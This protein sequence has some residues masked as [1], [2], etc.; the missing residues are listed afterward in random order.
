LQTLH[1]PELTALHLESTSGHPVCLTEHAS[2]P[3]VLFFYPKDNT[4]GCSMEVQDFRDLHASFSTLNAHILG[5]SRDTLKSHQKFKEKYS[6]PFGLLADPEEKLC[7]L[8]QVIKDKN[9]FG[10]KVRGIVRSTFLYDSKGNLHE[11]WHKVKVPGHAQIVL[12][13]LTE[14][15][16]ENP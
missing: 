13:T 16:K 12:N 15:L 3:L 8:Y 10:K 6:L 2:Q 9:M 4:P 5:V 7:Q 14:M 1:A 11:S